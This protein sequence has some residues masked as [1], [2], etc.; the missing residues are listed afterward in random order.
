MIPVIVSAVLL[1]ETVANTVV[2]FWQKSVISRLNR[3]TG[4]LRE[5]IRELQETMDRQW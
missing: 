3:E 2:Y 1:V 4:G 5:H